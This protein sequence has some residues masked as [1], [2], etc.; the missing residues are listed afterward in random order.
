MCMRKEDWYSAINSYLDKK[1]VF[2]SEHELGKEEKKEEF[3]VKSFFA[4]HFGLSIKNII[5]KKH[6]N[7]TNEQKE[8]E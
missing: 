4:S 2:A 1:K 8:S 3:K 6:S 5:I 7:K